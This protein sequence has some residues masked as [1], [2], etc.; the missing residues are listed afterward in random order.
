[1]L[2]WRLWR[3]AGAFKIEI[4]PALGQAKEDQ[5]LGTLGAGLMGTWE[6]WWMEAVG[7][8][9]WPQQGPTGYSLQWGSGGHP[10]DPHAWAVTPGP[11]PKGAAGS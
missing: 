2:I 5:S 3:E 8:R 1:M 11:F 4:D 7:T 10:Q 6:V 9:P